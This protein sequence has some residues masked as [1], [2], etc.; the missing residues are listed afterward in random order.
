MTTPIVN[1][2]AIDYAGLP[3]RLRGGMQ[4][5]IEDRIEPGSFLLAVLENDLR[6]ACTNAD[7]VNRHLLYDIVRWLYNNAPGSCWG[8]PEKVEAWLKNEKEEA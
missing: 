3:E 4:R 8:S 7:D 6:W 5:Y 2:K 1:G